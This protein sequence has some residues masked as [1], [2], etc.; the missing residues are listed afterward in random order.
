MLYSTRFIGSFIIYFDV[1]AKFCYYA[2]S[3]FSSF[4]LK[5]IYWGFLWLRPVL[6][7]LV[8]FYNYCIGIK[9]FCKVSSPL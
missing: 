5:E 3:R 2:Y 6:L 9:V 1:Y 4:Q 8:I 7:S